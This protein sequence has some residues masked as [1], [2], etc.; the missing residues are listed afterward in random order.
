MARVQA[1]I[2][3][4]PALLAQVSQSSANAG[5]ADVIAISSATK[6]RVRQALIGIQSPL[7]SA[8]LT[9][10]AADRVPRGCQLVSAVNVKTWAASARRARPLVRIEPDAG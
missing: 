10:Q 9:N 1:A 8:P 4:S 3:S 2:A 7:A 6:R 5:V